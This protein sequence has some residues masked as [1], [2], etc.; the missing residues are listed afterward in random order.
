MGDMA[1]FTSRQTAASSLD[2]LLE[3]C[4]TAFRMVGGIR[5]CSILL[6]DND[7]NYAT[8]QAGFDLHN[9]RYPA[10]CAKILVKDCMLLER[11]VTQHHPILLKRPFECGLPVLWEEVP[12][13]EKVSA[14]GMIPFFK[15]SQCYGAAGLVSEEE[16]DDLLELRFCSWQVIGDLFSNVLA[17]HFVNAVLSAEKGELENILNGIG[18]GIVILDRNL[19]ILRANSAMADMVS[20]KPSELVG[21]S[22]EHLCR[23]SGILSQPCPVREAITNKKV[24]HAIKRC[25][26]SQLE[27]DRYLKL[28]CFPQQNLTGEVTHAIVYI[29]D[30]SA[31]VRAEMLQKDLTHMI[32]HDIRNPLLAAIW[33]LDQSI[34]GA[35]GWIT[36]YHKG[37]LSSTR[38]SCDLLLCMLD[39]ILDVYT[40]EAGEVH[41]NLQQVQPQQFIQKAYKAIEALAHEKEIQVRFNLEEGLPEFIGDER[42]MVRVMINLF[43][44]AIKFSPK[45]STVIV[46]AQIKNEGWIQLMMTN[47]GP[48]IPREHL[49]KIFWKFYQVDKEPGIKKAG[50]GLGLAYC[51]LAVEAHGGK[52]WAESPVYPDGQGSRFI[53]TIPFKKSDGNAL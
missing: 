39:D 51:R 40:H 47:S 21:T 26:V 48:A 19:N 53:F 9:P 43:D 33:N 42:R 45:R 10:A 22:Y 4:L 46:D 5:R 50:L 44:N 3:E 35:H 14:I 20:K 15:S 52:I 18:H 41:L 38:D 30:I 49:E 17:H 31:I 7:P 24:I 6:L 28:S 8:L 1:L 11:C 12:D 34:S 27:Q 23:D 25:Q 37:I 16:V 2:T 32:L 36:S 29:R 13:H